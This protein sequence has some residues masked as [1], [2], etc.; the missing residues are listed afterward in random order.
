[1]SK[2]FPEPGELNELIR[3]IE[4]SITSFAKKG[5]EY[6]TALYSYFYSYPYWRKESVIE[7]VKHLVGAKKAEKVFDQVHKVVKNFDLDFFLRKPVLELIRR[8]ILLENKDVSSKLIESAEKRLRQISKNEMD[9]L[10]T[11]YTLILAPETSLLTKVSFAQDEYGFITVS[12]KQLESLIK[13][14]IDDVEKLLVESFLAFKLKT[15]DD[16]ILKFYP[17]VI[18]H[19]SKYLNIASIVNDV[20]TKGDLLSISILH[21]VV[22]GYG[23]KSFVPYFFGEPFESLCQK[24]VIE[25]VLENCSLPMASIVASEELVKSIYRRTLR[26]IEEQSIKELE[27]ELYNIVNG[28]GLHMECHSGSCLLFRNQLETPIHIRIYPWPTSDISIQKIIGVKII[29]IHGIPSDT[30]T[31]YLRS[32]P[33]DIMWLFFDIKERKALI[34]LT[35]YVYEKTQSFIEALSSK[36][37]VKILNLRQDVQYGGEKIGE[38]KMQTQAQIFIPST[39]QFCRVIRETPST[40][41]LKIAAA[42]ALETLG[43]RVSIE[44]AVKPGITID[45]WAEKNVVTVGSISNILVYVSCK[46][47]DKP[48]DLDELSK[49]IGKLSMLSV[50]PHIQIIIAPKFTSEARS[51]ALSKGFIVIETNERVTPE[52]VEKIYNSIL[53]ALSSLITVVPYKQIMESINKIETLE[54]RITEL[55]KRMNEINK[56]IEGIINEL[57]NIKETIK[58]TITT[59]Q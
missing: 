55:T 18:K 42:C 12:R 28:I 9:I 29:I 2:V 34:A 23:E 36:Y 53:N 54:N 25:G 11:V 10:R 24:T 22:S 8:G 58:S 13:I 15:W 56:E 50:K 3:R 35:D 6:I 16:I 48:V 52:N 27:N 26:T 41:Y 17:S 4:N 32:Q 49:D 14:S 57:K 47:I 21:H 45:I 39:L 44:H 20:Y 51:E 1:M 19:L 31:N 40:D 30:I 5:P 38:N 43:F 33:Q 37:N 59:K 7:T 46:N